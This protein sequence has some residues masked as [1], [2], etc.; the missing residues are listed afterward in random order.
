MLKVDI[1]VHCEGWS[2]GGYSNTLYFRTMKDVDEYQ[3]E[4][5]DVD[6]LN[7]QKVSTDEYLADYIGEL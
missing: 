1:W 6:V 5:P 4:N 3:K 7:I 2:T